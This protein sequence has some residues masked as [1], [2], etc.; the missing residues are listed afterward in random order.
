M[1]M[2]LLYGILCGIALS[3]FFSFGPAFFSLIRTSIQYGFRRA[4]PFAFGISGGDI[5]I[6]FLMLTA[7]KNLDLF[8]ILHNFWVASI[9][10]AVL[11]LMG[12]YYLRKEVTSLEGKESHVKF[13]S[14]GGEPR[15][16]SVLFQG[17]LINFVNPMIWIFWVSL[18]ALITGEL[19]LGI[20]ER[21]IFFLGMLASTLG[22][23]VLKCK[24]ASLLQRIITA[25]LLNI[26]NKVC[27]FIMFFFAAYMVFS[28]ANYQL[29]PKAQEREQQKKDGVAQTE[30]IK[31]IH[32]LQRADSTV[33]PEHRSVDTVCYQ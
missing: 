25:K 14:K 19:N 30:M 20:G 16:L 10:G 29:N 23:D 1:D 2:E 11:V 13:K 26:T 32:S 24:L 8:E 9:S 22:L 28:M 31:K 33:E 5:F 15:R 21:Y 3:L 27:A 12:F 17:F 6:V 18:I 7:L 4:V